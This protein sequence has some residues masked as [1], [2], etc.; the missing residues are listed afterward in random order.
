MDDRGHVAVVY[1]LA[2]VTERVLSPAWKMTMAVIRLVAR[3]KA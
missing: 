1:S 2:G 3:L